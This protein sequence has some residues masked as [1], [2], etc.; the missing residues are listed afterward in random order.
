MSN[1]Y[2]KQQ[3]TLPGL[4]F[5]ERER[6]F[7]KILGPMVKSDRDAD[8][9]KGDKA[10]TVCKVIDLQTGELARLIC[11]ALMVSALNDEGVDYVGKCYEI[12]VTA[13]K[14]PGKDY[15]GVEV[16]EIDCNGDYAGLPIK[17]LDAQEASEPANAK[18]ASK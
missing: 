1:D 3:V 16:Y 10:A 9:K 15:K 11:P 18:A 7:V 4:S 12:I 8:D 5:K 13:N 2:R 6:A 14:L 17:D